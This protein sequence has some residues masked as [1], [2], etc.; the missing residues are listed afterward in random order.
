MGVLNFNTLRY[1]LPNDDTQIITKFFELPFNPSNYFVFARHRN[2][3]RLVI[4]ELHGYINILV[5]F[6]INNIVV[7]HRD[8]FVEQLLMVDSDE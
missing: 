8:V 7:E 3:V 5:A 1:I 6:V 4:L 2:Q